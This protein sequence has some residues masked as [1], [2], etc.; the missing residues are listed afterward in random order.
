MRGATDNDCLVGRQRFISIHAPHA[1]CDTRS[2][3]LL[4]KSLISIH[5]PHAGCDQWDRIRSTVLGDFN[6]R[7]P[8][9]VRLCAEPLKVRLAPFQSTHPMRGATCG[10]RQGRSSALYFNPRTPCGVRPAEGTDVLLAGFISIH[11]P[12]AGCDPI[13]CIKQRIAPPTKGGLTKK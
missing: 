5:A 6:P 8:C 4:E 11:A 10:R 9:G 1:G 2:H 12:H 13:S 3:L 7:T